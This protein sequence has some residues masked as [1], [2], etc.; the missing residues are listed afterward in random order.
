MINYYNYYYNI[1]LQT[2]L[3]T[4]LFY[5]N[6]YQSIYKYIINIFISVL[7][8]DNTNFDLFLKTSSLLEIIS[9]QKTFFKCFKFKYK[10]NSIKI[11][12]FCKVTLNKTLSNYIVFILIL[13]YNPKYIILNF[14]KL[15]YLIILKNLNLFF[16][17]KF[18]KDFKIDFFFWNYYINFKFNFLKIKKKYL[19]KQI[20]KIL[21][22]NLNEKVFNI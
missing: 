9:G 10:F 5:K 13:S 7:N 6:I 8:I 11:N 15:T 2:E 21:N 19:Y 18:F 17:F 4:I 3:Y 16:N 12:F 1:I 14:L 20:I 22:Y